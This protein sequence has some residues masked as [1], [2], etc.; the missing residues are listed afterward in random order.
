VGTDILL[1][2]QPL[3][4]VQGPVPTKRQNIGTALKLFGLSSVEVVRGEHYDSKALIAAGGNT[5]VVAFRGTASKSAALADLQV[6]S[7]P[8]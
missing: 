8:A 3:I 6:G 1:P 5:I 4:V 7:L 2:V